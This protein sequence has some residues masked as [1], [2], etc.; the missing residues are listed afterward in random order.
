MEENNFVEEKKYYNESRKLAT[1]R[2]R[3][4]RKTIQCT[5]T[6]KTWKKAMMDEQAAKRG[7]SL[8]RY[9]MG[10]MEK[11]AKGQ[12]YIMPD[13]TKDIAVEQI[14]SIAASKDVKTDNI[15]TTIRS[16]SKESQKALSDLA[17][18]SGIKKEDIVRAL[19]T[20]ISADMTYIGAETIIES[21]ELFGADR[22]SVIAAVKAAGVD[23]VF[24]AQC[25]HTKIKDPEESSG[26]DEEEKE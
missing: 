3:K 19:L 12:V 25:E 13:I 10:M 15:K 22:E 6:F 18:S 17:D 2:Y 20:Y 24:P 14:K 21:L 5:L 11:D 8:N 9:Y 4:K 1:R 26:D 16:M 23:P 7:L